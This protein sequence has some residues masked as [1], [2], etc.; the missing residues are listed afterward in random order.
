VP[1][2]LAIIFDVGMT[3]LQF[4]G[5]WDQVLTQSWQT[6]AE[7]LLSEGY[8][9]DRDEFIRSFRELFT[10][11]IEERT[12]EHIEQPT[13]ELFCLVMERF[14]YTQLSEEQVERSLVRF[15]SVSEAHWHPKPGVNKILDHFKNEGYRMALIS[16][17]GDE[18][19]VLRL[20]DKG[21]LKE[22]FH[23]ILISASEGIRKPH[24]GLFQKVLQ[25]WELSPGQV[26]MV[27]DSLLEDILGA[28]ETGLHQ[29]WLK[30]HVDTPENRRIAERIV[31]EAIA[32]TFS[33]VPK[34]ID[35]M[36]VEGERSTGYG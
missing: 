3:L 21:G 19:N 22:Y 20:L 34:L 36:S 12:Q 31:P 11:R 24:V 7:S 9:I 25:A 1:L 35:E 4:R 27:G 23:P 14:G 6:L 15:Y 33:D 17:A 29:I 10:S 13:S 8:D 32:D 28:Q 2:I 26:V 5:D 30:E 16:N 18:A